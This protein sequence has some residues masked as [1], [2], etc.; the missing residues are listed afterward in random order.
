M[1]L[2]GPRVVLRPWRR[3]DEEAL[4]RHA[5]NRNVWRNL[6][7][8][9]PHPY[10]AGDA[11]AWVRQ[12]TTREGPPCHLAITLDGD[13]IG[14][15]G[16]ERLTDLARLT[17]EIGYWLGEAHW[18]RGLATEA[19][20]LTTAYAFAQFDFVRLQAGVLAWN[21]RSRRVLEKAGYALEARLERAVYK[22]GAVIDSWLYVRLRDGAA[23]GA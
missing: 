2:V 14:G 17:A 18:G 9:F 21:P 5:N 13:P 4:V 11:R 15:T 19:L 12:C 1:E 10:T 8:R 22:D 3:G 16:F 7:D 23:P 20:G 6:T